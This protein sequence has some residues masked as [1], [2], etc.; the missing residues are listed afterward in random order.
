MVFYVAVFFGEM[1]VQGE[2]YV[3]VFGGLLGFEFEGVVACL[4]GLDEENSVGRM[5]FFVKDFVVRGYYFEIYW[6]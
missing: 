4:V 5:E 6:V 2:G 1:V 3:E